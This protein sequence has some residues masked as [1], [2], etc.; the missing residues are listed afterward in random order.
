VLLDAAHAALMAEA[1]RIRDVIAPALP[2]L[3]QRA[4]ETLSLTQQQR[5]LR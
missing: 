2:E 5:R 1:D 4:P 3:H